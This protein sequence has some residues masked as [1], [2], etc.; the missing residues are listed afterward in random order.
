MTYQG[1]KK[2]ITE[3]MQ[4]KRSLSIFI[5]ITSGIAIY[6]AFKLFNDEII[7]EAKM[8]FVQPCL[9]SI[10]TYSIKDNKIVK[11]VEELDEKGQIEGARIKVLEDCTIIDRRNWYC[12]DDPLYP[13]LKINVVDRVFYPQESSLKNIKWKQLR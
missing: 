7:V 8:C 9:V 10:H 6:F 11:K 12:H 4:M 3:D 5:V 13:A 2:F 1:L